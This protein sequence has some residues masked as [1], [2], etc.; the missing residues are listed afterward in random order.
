[1][2]VLSCAALPEKVLI[3]FAVCENMQTPDNSAACGTSRLPVLTFHKCRITFLCKRRVNAPGGY[4][5]RQ[6][7]L[8]RGSR[9]FRFY[10]KSCYAAFPHVNTFKRLARVTG[11][12]L[13]RKTSTGYTPKTIIGPCGTARPV[14]I[15]RHES[16]FLRVKRANIII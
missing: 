13:L 12:I 9:C 4:S 3:V 16:F 8:R 5:V 7:A 6:A 1:M 15:P 14:G 10:I 11:F 2:C